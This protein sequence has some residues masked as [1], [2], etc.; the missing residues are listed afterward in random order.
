MH[1]WTL[2]LE[3]IVTF[4]E[5]YW[6]EVNKYEIWKNAPKGEISANIELFIR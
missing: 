2:I 1:N 6:Q 4:A 3:K 5:N